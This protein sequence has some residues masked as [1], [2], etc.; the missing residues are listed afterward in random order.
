MYTYINQLTPIL[1]EYQTKLLRVVVDN[2]SIF[3]ELD[4][5]KFTTIV[6]DQESQNTYRIFDTTTQEKI[7]TIH[8]FTVVVRFIEEKL[9]YY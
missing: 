6:I 7:S 9:K 2:D 5:E 1:Q 8:N 3:I 4:N